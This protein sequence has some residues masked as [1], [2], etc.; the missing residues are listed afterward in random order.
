MIRWICNVKPDQGISSDDLQ[1]LRIPSLE[2]RL[3]NNRLRWFGHVERSRPVEGDDEGKGWIYKIRHIQVDG[4]KK[5]GR[6]KK[7]WEQTLK[8]D[9]MER[10]MS[11]VNPHDRDAWRIALRADGP[12]PRAGGLQ[13]ARDSTDSRLR[14]R[15][16]KLDK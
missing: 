15:V 8:K 2:R 4:D 1:M 9:R 12:T 3:Q 14:P 11:S 6:P 5:L 7:T 10:D 16:L 13:G